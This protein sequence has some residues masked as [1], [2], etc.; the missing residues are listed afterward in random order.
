[1]IK[2]KVYMDSTCF[3]DMAKKAV[4]V[5]PETRDDDV[6]FCKKLLEAHRDSQIQIFTAILTI[7]ECQHADGI[8]NTNV[9]KL[10]KSMLTSGQFVFLVQDTVIIADKARNLKW[11]HDLPFKGADSLHIASALEMG[12]SEFLT[13]DDRILSRAEEILRLGIRVIHPHE[14]SLLPDEYRQGALLPS[15]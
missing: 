6:W 13:T 12:C 1:M 4:G 5:L 3:I 14:T 9:Q 11:T 15:S 8:Y 10:F 7:A 2:P